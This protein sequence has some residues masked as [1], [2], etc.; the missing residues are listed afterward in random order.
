MN[1]VVK[2]IL[3][4]SITKTIIRYILLCACMKGK[5]LDNVIN[6]YI[7][8]KKFI[9]AILIGQMLRGGCGMTGNIDSV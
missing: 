6:K 2:W 1:S 9:N 4:A 3:L 7:G 5:H 8:Y